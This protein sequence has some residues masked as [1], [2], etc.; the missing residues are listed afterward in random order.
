MENSIRKAK[1]YLTDALKAGLDLGRGDGPL[2]HNYV[3]NTKME[4]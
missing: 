4:V 3:L 1:E 2:M